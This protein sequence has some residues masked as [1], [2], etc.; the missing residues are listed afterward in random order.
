M[1][2]RT[3]A[4][5]G[6]NRTAARGARWLAVLALLSVVC[7]AVPSVAIC[8][9]AC[10]TAATSGCETDCSCQTGVAIP[11]STCCLHDLGGAAA[12][13]EPPTSLAPQPVVADLATPAGEIP[14]WTPAVAP[15]PAA[16]PARSPVAA[17]D[18]LVLRI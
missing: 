16:A 12:S 14:S 10:E 9:D 13:P 3:A 15:T 11:A 7:A 4:W 6:R 18:R 1:R 2:K 17:V 5:T 8:D